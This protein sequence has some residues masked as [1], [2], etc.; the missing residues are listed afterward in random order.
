MV[1]AVVHRKQCCLAQRYS[2]SPSYQRHGCEGSA[3]SVSFSPPPISAIQ[4]PSAQIAPLRDPW[5]IFLL[6]DNV[7]SCFIKEDTSTC[8]HAASIERARHRRLGLVYACTATLCVALDLH[9]ESSAAQEGRALGA[10]SCKQ[11]AC[12][13]LAARSASLQKAH[14]VQSR[15]RGV[16]IADVHD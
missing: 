4:R 7:Q 13:Q 8:A 2:D 10:L 1:T 14:N 9:M 11:S 5:K 3:A 15:S 6:I 16:H 12:K